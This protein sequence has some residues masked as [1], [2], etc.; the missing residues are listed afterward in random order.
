MLKLVLFSGFVLIQCHRFPFTAVTCS[1]QR[2]F[3]N[4]APVFLYTALQKLLYNYDF[5]CYVFSKI[6][7]VPVIKM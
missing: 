5:R 7:P 1:S 4:M 3:M 2:C 6:I